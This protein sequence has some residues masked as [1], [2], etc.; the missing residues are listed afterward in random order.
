M[1]RPAA[2]ARLPHARL[3]P[4]AFRG[5]GDDRVR[6]AGR[7]RLLD[8]HRHPAAAE[9]ADTA[10]E[11]AELMEIAEFR[12]G[13]MA[14]AMLQRDDVIG[15]FR[16]VLTFKASSH[17][18]TFRL[19]HAAVRVG[20]F[21]VMHHKK[22]HGRARPSVIAP[23]LMPP[24][25]PPGHPAYPSGH[26]TQAYLLAMVL[27]EVMPGIAWGEGKGGAK[28]PVTAADLAQVAG[29]IMT[30]VRTVPGVAGRITHTPCG[31]W[32]SGLR[33]CAR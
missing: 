31:A 7:A 4:A 11:I 12:A 23:A 1:D 17:P 28:L 14:E 2:T 15:Y 5:G 8:Q 32:P 21:I 16:G 29:S 33:A 6:D 10:D 9:P 3:E 30:K 27:A 24:I 18:W 20:Q 13:A 22:L 26:A 19:C 25:D